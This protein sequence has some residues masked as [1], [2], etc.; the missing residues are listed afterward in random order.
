MSAAYSTPGGDGG[1]LT[2][3]GGL[4]GGEGE[5]GMSQLSLYECLSQPTISAK[6]V[7]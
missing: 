7:R 5:E 6:G 4:E 1:S 2:S 3:S